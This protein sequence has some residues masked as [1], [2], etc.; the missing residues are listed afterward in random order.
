M[1]YGNKFGQLFIVRDTPRERAPKL[2][3][4]KAPLFSVAR[5]H[6]VLKRNFQRF[7]IVKGGRK[8]VQ[9]ATEEKKIDDP[10][11]SYVT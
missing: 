4:E 11:V 3:R 8:C 6:F 5:L 1:K 7:Q 9:P 2:R 10:R